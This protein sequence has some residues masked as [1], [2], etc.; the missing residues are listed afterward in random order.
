ML[1]EQTHQVGYIG[2]RSRGISSISAR[3]LLRL[4]S[5]AYYL[6]LCS[7]CHHKQMLPGAILLPRKDAICGQDMLQDKAVRGPWRMWLL[8]GASNQASREP[9]GAYAGRG[10]ARHSAP[11]QNAD[12]GLGL[13]KGT[14]IGLKRDL[15]WISVRERGKTKCKWT[16]VEVVTAGGVPCCGEAALILSQS[17]WR[18][19]PQ[20]A[21]TVERPQLTY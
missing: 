10:H 15:D 13:V 16:D 19:D 20:H 1:K 17:A 4:H 9:I 18:G 3:D 5:L 12:L 7:P 8:D 21:Q 14:K 6:L 2:P 11:D